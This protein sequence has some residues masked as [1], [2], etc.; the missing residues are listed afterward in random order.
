[1]RMDRIDKYAPP[2]VLMVVFITF[3]F[4]MK[5]C[6]GNFDIKQVDYDGFEHKCEIAGGVSL[7]SRIC[8]AKSAIQELPQ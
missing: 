2:I 7:N 1:M 6:A 4:S 5:N 8:L 3:A